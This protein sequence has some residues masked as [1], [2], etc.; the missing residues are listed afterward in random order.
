VKAVVSYAGSPDLLSTHDYY[1]SHFGC[2]LVS[3]AL[4]ER[5]FMAGMD[6]LFHKLGILPSYG[7]NLAPSCLVPSFVGGTPE[8][9]PELYRLGSPVEHVGPHCPPTLLLQGVHDYSGILPDVRRLYRVLQQAGVTAVYIEYSDTDHAFEL[10]TLGAAAWSPAA[11][12]AAY[13]TE[14]FLALMV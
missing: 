11:R 9:V 12:A 13:D 1:R 5:W 7:A 3:N 14:R 8:E 2:Y 4:W 10:V 6:W